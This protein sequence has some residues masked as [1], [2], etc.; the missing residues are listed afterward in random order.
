MEYLLDIGAWN[1]VFA[2]PA[3]LVDQHLKLAG[4]VQLKVILWILRHAGES[5]TAEDVASALSLQ[6]ADVRDA[7]TYWSE[8]GLL[9]SRGSVLLPPEPAPAEP[10]APAK[11]QEPVS[12]DTGNTT[13]PA[14]AEPVRSLRP[15]SRPQKPDRAYLNSRI[16]ADPAIAYLMQTADEIFGRPTSPNDKATLLMIVETDGLPSEVVIM[17][18]QYAAGIGQCNIRFIEKMAIRWA[19]QQIQ[20]LEQAEEELRRLT[21]SRTAAAAV[22]RV[23]GATA[24]SPTKKEQEMAHRW[25]KEW[26]FSEEMVRKAYEI[27]VDT[28]GEYKPGYVN[29]ILSR[30]RDASIYTPAQAESDSQKKRPS[31]KKGYGS[32]YDLAEYEHTS[33][34][35]MMEEEE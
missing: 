17:L 20:T 23:I 19:D 4:A 35:D 10:S 2:V 9:C 25:L 15:L 31:P 16:E 12:A 29:K 26:Q 6:P 13:A 34:V 28:I 22:Q 24:H 3:D 21:E 32:T 7:M 33:V 18:M 14:E 27:C 5:F 1:R 30:W 11:K 8:T